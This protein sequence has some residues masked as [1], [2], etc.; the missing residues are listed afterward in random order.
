MCPRA[1]DTDCDFAHPTRPTRSIL[2][3]HAHIDAVVA[4]PDVSAALGEKVQEP[5]KGNA[6]VEG[7][8]AC[9]FYGESVKAG[10]PDVPSVDSVRVVLVSGADGTRWFNDYRSK[11]HAIA[12]SGLGDS[13]FW[14]GAASVNVLKGSSYLRISV[15]TTKGPSESAAKVLAETAVAR[16]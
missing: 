2:R 4:H 16:M 10:D 3:R 8:V 13:A 12:I 9:V 11:V 7:G 1:D 6:T 15:I 14:D 5:V